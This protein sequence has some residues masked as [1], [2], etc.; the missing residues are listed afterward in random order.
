MA[1]Q[2]KKIYDFNKNYQLLA[3]AKFILFKFFIIIKYAHID[4]D[5]LAFLPNESD[6]QPHSNLQSPQK[7][8]E[9]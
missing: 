4:I 3:E 5:Q 9:S 7:P 2:H 8:N 1:Q 6:P